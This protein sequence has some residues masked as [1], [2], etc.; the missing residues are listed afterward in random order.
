MLTIGLTGGIGSGKSAVAKMLAELGA[1]V[2][3]ADKVAQST[4][5]PGASA[6]KDVVE[7]FGQA[8]VAP[9]G[10]I[11]RTKLGP[12]VFADPAQLKKL[13]SIVWPRTM[14]RI[15]ELTTEMR[16]KGEKLPIVVEAAILIEANWMPLFDEI[17]LV[18]ASR[19]RVIARVERDR[20]MKSAQ[21]EARMRAQLPDSERMRH[22]KVVIRNEGTLDELQAEVKRLWQDAVS[23][24]A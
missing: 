20:G 7:A 15:R 1:Q 6:Y 21:T 16:A 10:T 19:D 14:D 22:A 4:Y 24:N 12:L 2:L 18:T 13:T 8:I 11:D 23:R 3:D 17:W 5:A 9:D